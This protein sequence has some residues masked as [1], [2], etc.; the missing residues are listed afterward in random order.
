[1]DLIRKTHAWHDLAVIP[2]VAGASR[3]NF[4]SGNGAGRN[5]P[6]ILHSPARQDISRLVVLF[7]PR[8]VVL[9]AQP[10]VKRKRRQDF[11]I[12]LKIASGAPL[13]ISH[14]TQRRCELRVEDSPKDEVGRSIARSIGDISV[15]RIGACVL[16]LPQESDVAGV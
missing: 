10:E 8:L 3:T 7:I 15:G 12:I 6:R 11:E 16:K 5:V 4:G 1:M 2:V 13:P 9:V 14:P